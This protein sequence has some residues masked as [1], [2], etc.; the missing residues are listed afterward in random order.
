MKALLIVVMLAAEGALPEPSTSDVTPDASPAVEVPAAPDAVT[1]V[2]APSET[3]SARAT[4][5][6]AEPHGS[7]APA[8]KAA[9]MASATPAPSPAV[10]DSATAAR[11]EETRKRLAE[12]EQK[13]GVASEK[14]S[15]LLSAIDEIDEEIATRAEDIGAI[16]D[17]VA[18]ARLRSD[19]DKTAMESIRGRILKKKRWLA[20]RVRS[21]FVHGR[22][23]YLKVLFSAESYPDLV[24]K[25][26]FQSIIARRDAKMV[27]ELRKDL[28]EVA[29]HRADYDQDLALLEGMESDARTKTAELALTREFRKRLLGEVH[30]ER[31]SDE[32]MRDALQAAA[33]RLATQVGSLQGGTTEAV[34]PKAKTTFTASKGHLGVPVAARVKLGF[35]PYRHPKLGLPMIHQGVSYAATAGSDVHAVFDGTVEM[36][37][38]FSSYGQVLVIDHGEGWRTLYAHNGRLLKKEGDTIRAGEIV[39]ISGDTGA[40][41][42]PE[43]YFA[44][45]R[46]GKPVDPADWL[47]R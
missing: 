45:F 24:Q 29:K 15:A 14:E 36:A 2:A 28:G 32:K 18:K 8:A 41:D 43:L 31:A 1:S 37:R 44:I 6:S 12:I 10:L 34:A 40:L 13:L 22:P 39:A 26:R 4:A 17:Q 35:G 23:G 19:E 47:T 3:P 20:S 38:W 5:T 46:E 42:G 7:T 16:H 21:A 30:G 25:T 9:A 11:L 33:D 27:G